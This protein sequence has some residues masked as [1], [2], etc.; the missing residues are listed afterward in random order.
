[1]EVAV[2]IVTGE[3]EVDPDQRDPFLAGRVDVMRASRAEAGCIEYTMS[4]DPLQPGRVV[5]LEKWEN[6]ESLDAHLAGLRAGSSTEPSE[7]APEIPV[8]STSITVYDIAGERPL[9]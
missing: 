6:Q 9:V 7:S 2:V 3:L 4:A 1:M 8:K 5:L